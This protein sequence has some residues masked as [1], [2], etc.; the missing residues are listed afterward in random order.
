MKKYKFLILFTVL[1]LL[2]SAGCDEKGHTGAANKLTPKNNKVEVIKGDFIYRLVSEKREYRES[3][4]VK[5]YAELE[6]TGEKE[7]IKISHGGSPFFF[8]ISEK[9]R[10]VNID[11]PMIQPL[12]YS[13]MVKGDPLRKEYAGSGSYSSEDDEDFIKFMKQ[14]MNNDFPV[15]EYTVNGSADFSVIT[16]ENEEDMKLTGQIEFKVVPKK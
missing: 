16:S 3:E 9:T 1:I 14:I 7:E 11:Y 12:I 8:P 13:T 2:S 10:G 4:P 6:Y 15:G 5:I